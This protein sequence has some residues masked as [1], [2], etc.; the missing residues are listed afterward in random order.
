MK[1]FEGGL[2]QNIKAGM[3]RWVG[4]SARFEVIHMRELDK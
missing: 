4:T 2:A 1:P 3:S